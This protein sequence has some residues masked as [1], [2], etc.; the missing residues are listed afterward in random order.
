ME[1]FLGIFY[2]YRSLIA[3][4]VIIAF[5]TLMLVERRIMLGKRSWKTLWI[6]AVYVIFSLYMVFMIVNFFTPKEG[7]NY[8]PTEQIK[9]KTQV[10]QQQQYIDSLSTEIS[11]LRNQL[12][13]KESV[14]TMDSLSLTLFSIKL[15]SLESKLA[16]H[17]QALLRVENLLLEEPQNLL[18]LPLIQQKISGIEKDIDQLDKN[19]TILYTQFADLTWKKQSFWVNIIIACFTL[20]AGF[21]SGQFVQ[22]RR[23]LKEQ[24]SIAEAAK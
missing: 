18:T 17:D 24:S 12:L 10:N 5:L 16:V 6:S 14:P 2:N 13:I 19:N 1:R 23:Q 21:F 11:T 9:L 22:K 20:I 4:F 7:T 8:I 3:M 15:T